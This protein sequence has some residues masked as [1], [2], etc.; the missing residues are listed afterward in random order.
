[1][2]GFVLKPDIVASS[3]KCTGIAR[4]TLLEGHEETR[5]GC[6]SREPLRDR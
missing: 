1:M 5:E 4:A 3:S 6:V 2:G